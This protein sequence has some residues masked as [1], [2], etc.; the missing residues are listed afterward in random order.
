MAVAVAVA[1]AEEAMI[2]GKM[3]GRDPMIPTN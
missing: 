2:P 3:C 1:V